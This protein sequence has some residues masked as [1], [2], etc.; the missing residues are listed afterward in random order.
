MKRFVLAALASALVT[1]G[2]VVVLV[3]Q[4]RSRRPEARDAEVVFEASG[5]E[6]RRGRKADDTDG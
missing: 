4:E 6:S 5:D 1:A 2:I 3:S